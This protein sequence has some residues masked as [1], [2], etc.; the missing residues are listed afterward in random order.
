MV[1][2]VISS[3]V[4]KYVGKIKDE[5]IDRDLTSASDYAIKIGG[6]PYGEYN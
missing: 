5:E 6:L 2:W 4:V 1:V 3:K